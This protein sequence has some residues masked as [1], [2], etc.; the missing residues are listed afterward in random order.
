MN[1]TQKNKVLTSLARLLEEHTAD[2]LD[3]NATDLA[4]AHNLDATLLERLQLDT[5]KIESMISSIETVITLPNPEQRSISE[6]THGNGLIMKNTTVPFGTILIIYESRPDVT[7]EAS[8]LAFKSGNKVLLKGGKEARETNL[9]LVKLWHE[10]LAAHDVDTAYVTYFDLD[11]Q[12]TQA[13][14]TENTHDVDLIIPRGGEGLISFVEK[15]ATVPVLV[16]GRGNNFLYL[17]TDADISMAID[18]I[19]NGKSRVSVCNALDNVLINKHVPSENIEA[20]I[21]ALQDAGI[22]VLADHA[23]A[24]AHTE[25]EEVADIEQI[26]QQEFLSARIFLHLVEDMDTAIQLINTYSG[27]HSAAIVS[28]NQARATQFQQEVDCA[29]VYHNASTRFTD[30]GQFGLGGEI[31]ISTQKLHCR[32]PIGLESLVTNKWFISGTGQIR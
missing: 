4:N 16:S 32:G 23:I 30:G 21:T 26:L 10:A 1:T 7:I 9:V 17:D 24:S 29:A 15:H 27:G 22:T 2:I 18:I 5:K 13:L 28:N 31:G 12:E 19:I 25:V 3:A 6:Y 11:R 14:I 8:I 20:I